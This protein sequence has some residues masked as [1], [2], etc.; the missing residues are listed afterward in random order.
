MLREIQPTSERHL[1]AR[2]RRFRRLR[3]LKQGHVAEMLGVSQGLVSRWEAGIHMPTLEMCTRIRR[4]LGVAPDSTS[5][6]ALRKLVEVANVPVHLI[7]DTTH[8]LLAASHAREQ[9]WEA[10]ADAFVGS[11]LWR[12]ATDQIVM[13]EDRLG[14]HGWFDRTNPGRL[15][16]LTQGNGSAEMRILPSALEWE[17]I[18]LADGRMG[19][20]V[21][22]IAFA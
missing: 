10:S 1:G 17:Q 9:E 7:C 2:L 13:A 16:I 21:T 4:L 12:F 14:D 19:R 5:D 22:T 18:D 6:R 11:S 3:I 15:S 20:L 8:R